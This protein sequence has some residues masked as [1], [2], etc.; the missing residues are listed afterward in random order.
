MYSFLLKNE[1]LLFFRKLTPA[2]KAILDFIYMVIL[3]SIYVSAYSMYD[4]CKAIFRRGTE[5][6]SRG[7]L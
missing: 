2:V 6:L 4:N 5:I 3:S 7:L 1:F